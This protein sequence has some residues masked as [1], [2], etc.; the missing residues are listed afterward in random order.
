[1]KNT[2]SIYGILLI[3][4]F[5]FSCVSPRGMAVSNIPVESD[6]IDQNL[7]RAEGEDKSYKIFMIPLGKPDISK[8]LEKAINE[9]KG[10]AMINIQ[11]Y[12]REMNFIIFG[13]NAAIVTGDVVKLK[14]ADPEPNK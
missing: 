12:E 6:K 2:I 9:K 4:L 7:G 1:M 5:L 3:S 13:C 10:D 11:L 8:A 14:K